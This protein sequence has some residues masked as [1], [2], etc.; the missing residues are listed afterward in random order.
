MN[1]TLLVAAVWL[2]AASNVTAQQTVIEDPNAE[3]RAVTPFTAIRISSAID[4]YLSQSSQEAVAVSAGDI[5]IRNGIKVA[6]DNGV[7]KIWYENNGLNLSGNK[8]MKAYVAFRSINHLEA[9][10]SSDVYVNG[11]IKGDE[12]TITLSGAS[13]FKGSVQLNTLNLMQSGASDVTVTGNAANVQ[14]QA[15]G[16]SDCEGYGLLAETCTVHASGASDI[17]ITVNKA[18][19]ATATGA[20][21]VYYKGEAAVTEVRSSGGSNITRKS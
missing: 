13:D 6:V 4:L 19:T 7:L 10:G 16:A 14:V 8:K 2:F 12:L 15:S 20:S 17:K 5:K 9:S 3:V 18:L 11:S 1:R 21:S